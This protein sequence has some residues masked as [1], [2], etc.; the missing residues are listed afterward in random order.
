MNS[1]TDVHPF[2]TRWEIEPY[3]KAHL[4]HPNSSLPSPISDDLLLEDSLNLNRN[5]LKLVQILRME[6][7]PQEFLKKLFFRIEQHMKF[8][9]LYHFAPTI[10][11]PKEHDLTVECF[12]G[13]ILDSRN[14]WKLISYSFPKVKKLD[15]ELFKNQQK[16]ISL[17]IGNT[18]EYYQKIDGISVTLYFYENEWNVCS[19]WEPQ[20][21]VP[22][23]WKKPNSKQLELSSYFW[24][25]WKKLGYPL[26]EEKNR[27]GEVR[28][29]C[30]HSDHC[31]LWTR[32]R[33]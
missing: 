19:K 4:Q 22:Y 2:Y 31:V 12:N 26:P 33:L 14:N 27:Y 6:N 17:D 29:I 7:L 18:G 15:Y 5:E 23:G 11:S 28:T 13:V 30:F 10:K 1:E 3:V 20:G 8:E 24:S 21:C 16:T 32:R 9:N 25:V